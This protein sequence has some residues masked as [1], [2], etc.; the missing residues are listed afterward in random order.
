MRGCAS[1]SRNVC[2]PKREGRRCKILKTKRAREEK[3]GEELSSPRKYVYGDILGAVCGIVWGQKQHPFFK[4]WSQPF[5]YTCYVIH[6]FSRTGEEHL[7]ESKPGKS[8]LDYIRVRSPHLGSFVFAIG[9]Y[10]T[11]H[12]DHHPFHAAI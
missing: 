2:G 4:Q 5:P 8:I 1:T 9:S 3:T 12:P 10:R 7:E 6:R 11:L